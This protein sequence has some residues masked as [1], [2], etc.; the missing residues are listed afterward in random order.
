M[1]K[2]HSADAVWA[3]LADLG[4][5]NRPAAAEPSPVITLGHVARLWIPELDNKAWHEAVHAKPVIEIAAHQRQDVRD[6]PRRLVREGLHLEVALRGLEHDDR[7][8]ARRGLW[9]GSR[10]LTGRPLRPYHRRQRQR[11]CR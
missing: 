5:A 4:H 10:L 2:R 6:R 7:P 3:L 8:G 9:R 11:H 1:G